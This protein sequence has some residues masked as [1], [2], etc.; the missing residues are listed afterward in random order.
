[1]IK[2][3]LWVVLVKAQASSAEMEPHAPEH[4]R[5]MS[6][7]EDKGV[8]WGSGPFVTPGRVVSDGLTS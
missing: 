4:L 5:Y 3:T 2:K 8:L 7:L 1:M 6:D